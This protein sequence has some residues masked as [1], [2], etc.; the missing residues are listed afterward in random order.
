MSA[1]GVRRCWDAIDRVGE[2]TAVSSQPNDPPNRPVGRR[3]QNKADKWQR[4][5]AAARQ[6][7]DERGFEDTTTVEISRAAGVGAGTLYL[8]VES[9]EQLLF[10]VFAEDIEAA[11]SA[12]FEAVDA[13]KSMADQ[14]F[15]LLASVSTFHEAQPTIARTYVLELSSVIAG[16]DVGIGA[17]MD[18]TLDIIE[19]TLV[20]ALNGD[21]PDG[22]DTA[23][24][25]RNIFAIWL[26][27]MVY[28][29]SHPDM[30]LEATLS[31]IRTAVDNAVFG[32][33]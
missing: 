31:A 21:P 32:I 22:L 28:H 5:L 17:V 16:G 1:E 3:E 13:D 10:A 20:R 19:C 11:W 8:Y 33:S 7:F 18:R 23:V 14:I 6:L 24:T 2:V 30:P 4:I 25:A 29:Y 15:E 9:K 26:F 12:A 27:N